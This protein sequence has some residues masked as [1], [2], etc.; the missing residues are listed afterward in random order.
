MKLCL[1]LK[2]AD[3][4]PR[5]RHGLCFTLAALQRRPGFLCHGHHD[6]GAHLSKQLLVCQLLHTHTHI[7]RT[8]EDRLSV[9]DKDTGNLNAIISDT[10]SLLVSPF[11]SVPHTY[12]ADGS[13]SPL[14]GKLNDR[15]QHTI[16]N[17]STTSI[18]PAHRS[19]ESYQCVG[20]RQRLLQVAA[21][22]GFHLL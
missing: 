15:S 5:R 12:G 18:T 17:L 19:Q 8:Q 1:S 16:N 6:A 11:L 22:G 20:L 13:R 3:W 4:L 21:A 2:L 14:G 7:K 9:S 10:P